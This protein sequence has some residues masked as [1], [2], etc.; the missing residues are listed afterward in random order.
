MIAEEKVG[1]AKLIGVEMSVLCQKRKDQNDD[2]LTEL[3]SVTVFLMQW[4]P[5]LQEH[6][7]LEVGEEGGGWVFERM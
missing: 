1:G 7:Q 4:F 6:V 2:A 5:S 3:S